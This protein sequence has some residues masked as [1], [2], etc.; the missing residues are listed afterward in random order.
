M[1]MK[2]IAVKV[3]LVVTCV[4]IVDSIANEESFKEMKECDTR[5]K[6]PMAT[7]PV[8]EMKDYIHVEVKEKN[9]AA[10]SELKKILYKLLT[11]STH[12]HTYTC[13]YTYLLFVGGTACG[14]H[15]SQCYMMCGHFGKTCNFKICRCVTRRERLT[16][17]KR[18]LKKC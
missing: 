2:S 11:L 17:D 7:I 14:I 18:T 15:A 10:M 16:K 8:Q 3:L 13:I 6:G 4:I 12:T 9:K 5:D 1:N